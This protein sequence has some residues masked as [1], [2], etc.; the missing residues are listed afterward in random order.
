MSSI[1]DISSTK[2]FLKTPISG[3][4]LPCTQQEHLLA[5]VYYLLIHKKLLRPLLLPFQP[6]S[7][8]KY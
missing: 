5:L 1:I 6:S 3:K 2:C 7:L 4:T 8:D